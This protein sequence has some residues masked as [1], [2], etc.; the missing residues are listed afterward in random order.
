LIYKEG[1]VRTLADSGGKDKMQDLS[2][3]AELD[4][5]KLELERIIENSWSKETSSEPD[6]SP[7]N[8]AWG[9][10]AVTALVIDDYFIGDIV[11]AEASLPDRRKK[12]HYFNK[13][14]DK[15]LDLTRKQFPKGTI[16]P[17]GIPKTKEFSTTRE[18]ILSYPQT[19]KRYEILKQRVKEGV[20]KL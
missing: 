12:S 8:P 19:V 6:W 1:V 3:K 13:I 17:A 4:G 15:E 2:V 11:W 9:Q 7:D 10:C 14:K 18:Y 20:D 16:I 5:L